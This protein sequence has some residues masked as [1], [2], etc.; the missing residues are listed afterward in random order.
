ML[1]KDLLVVG[2]G[3]A[4]LTLA[5]LS[6][7][8]IPVTII[9]SN[10]P[11]DKASSRASG[12]QPRTLDILDQIGV[13][14]R[15][16]CQAIELLGNKIYVDGDQRYGFSFYDPKTQQH[17]LSIDQ[18]RIERLLEEQ[19]NS[20][21]TAVQ[22]GTTLIKLAP[23]EDHVEVTVRRPDQEL[24]KWSC[25]FVVGCDGGR[26]IVRRSADI[27]FPGETYQERSFMCEAL[28]QGDLEAG[29]MHYFVGADSRLVLVP[30]NTRGLFKLSG[31]LAPHATG[32]PEEQVQALVLKHG[33][34]RLTLE[35]LTD[36]RT[37]SIHARI[38]DKFVND[39]L[40]LCGDAA[41]LFP[42]NGG[43]GMNVAIEDAAILANLFG[44]YS[45]T[46]NESSLSS[47]D[48][49]AQEVRVRLDEV[50]ASRSRF[51]YEGLRQGLG[52]DKE[53]RRIEKE[54]L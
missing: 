25:S 28:V 6:L 22:W 19:L 9:S 52:A 23:S 13:L 15:V 12:L 35:H 4:G 47:Y 38:A 3:P 44:L 2:A 10:L 14:A 49:R 1:H 39:R 20:Q 27:S 46:G 50:R 16:R 40:F 29:Y 42:P 30:L 24:E 18:W 31:A 37:Y 8:H 43:Q 21:G 5:N 45:K 11:D 32:S 41:H 53:Q 26:S 51:S 34:G 33:Q 7:P 48:G 36:F 54:E 17:G